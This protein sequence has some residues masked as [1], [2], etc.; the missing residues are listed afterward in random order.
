MI[1]TD[2]LLSC[3]MQRRQYLHPL[4]APVVAAIV[5]AIRLHGLRYFR[6]LGKD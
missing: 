5:R 3:Y 1:V 2:F 6:S 4:H